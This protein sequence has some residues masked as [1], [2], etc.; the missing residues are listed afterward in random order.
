ML[1]PSPYSHPH[2]SHFPPR[3]TPPFPPPLPLLLSF[4]S[5]SHP[6]LGHFFLNLLTA[7]LPFFLQ[8]LLF[9][10]SVLISLFFHRL[11]PP[12]FVS[13][14]LIVIFVLFFPFFALFPLFHFFILFHPLLSTI[15][16][17]ILFLLLLISFSLPPHLPLSCYLYY[18]SPTPSVDA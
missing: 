5:Y 10:P 7:S 9:L 8:L 2:H 11:S 13:F 3:H 12:L 18:P 15:L 6:L 14:F 4:S 17:F 1:F 16:L